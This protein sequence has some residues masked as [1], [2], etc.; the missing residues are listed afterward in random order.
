MPAEESEMKQIPWFFSAFALP[1][2]L[3]VATVEGDADGLAELNT[4]ESVLSWPE[5]L[6]RESALGARLIVLL[7]GLNEANPDRAELRTI[8]RLYHANGYDA[9]AKHLYDWLIDSC[10]DNLECARLNYLAAQ[11]VK[12]K[13][14]SERAMFYLEASV[15]AYDEYGL[16]LVQLGEARFKVGDLD[17]AMELFL[18]A[19]SIDREL[20]S[21]YVGLSRVFERR[22][23]TEQMLEE[24]ESILEF[25]E[26]NSAALA[27]LSQV[28]ARLGD[29][30]R[31]YEAS[32]S[33][34]YSASAPENDP[35]FQE[36]LDAIYDVQRLDFLFLDYFTLKRYGEALPYLERMEA[37]DPENP[38]YSRYRAVMYMGSGYYDEAEKELYEGLD[39]GGEA[40]VFYPL[41]VK[42]MDLRGNKE[43][44]ERTARAAVARHGAS[45]ELNL[46]W[47]RLLTEKG[48]DE[49]A[50]AVLEQGI[51]SDP[52]LLEL[53]FARARLG[54]K[55]GKF[56]EARDSLRMVR[57]LSPMNA[58]ALV[59]AAL[60]L[61]EAG[62]FDE[63]LPFLKQSHRVAPFYGEATELLSDAHYELGMEAVKK[64]S[65][66]EA[67]AS[68]EKSLNLRPRR[69][70]ALGAVAQVTVQSG[71]FGEAETALKMFLE[72]AGDRPK[73]LTVYGD[74]LFRN[75][76]VEEAREA[77]TLA[78]RQA[79]KEGDDFELQRNLK[80]RLGQT[81]S[82]ADEDG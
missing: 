62:R 82:I 31:A 30:K 48:A 5:E 72:V 63:A 7:E 52:Y 71:R 73:I 50:M 28:Y 8:V 15:A 46:E 58:E 60:V 40:S 3:A 55:M 23:Q 64:N 32:E 54:M 37:L 27:L 34:E 80:S 76:K 41:L 47:S 36:V 67:L 12:E 43:E 18:Q 22:G 79:A 10:E 29:E 25:D 59:R 17:A 16:A 66:E 42:S 2:F 65:V 74:V 77:W 39:K 44:A 51:E 81:S 45:G 20:P 57:Q 19:K 38:R 14:D 53:H 61:M 70:D 4:L 9:K 49:A 33:I 1:F 78:L 68:F 13:G 35:W 56:A 26:F 75:R 11:L 21:A 6:S 69:M 24:L